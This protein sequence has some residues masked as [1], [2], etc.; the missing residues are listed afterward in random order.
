MGIKPFF[1]A[2]APLLILSSVSS[3]ADDARALIALKTQTILNVT[4][5]TLEAQEINFSVPSSSLTHGKNAEESTEALAQQLKEMAEK[6]FSKDPSTQ[7]QMRG[8]KF[9]KAASWLLNQTTE[10]YNEARSLARN[11]GWSAGI[12]YLICAVNDWA[13]PPLLLALGQPAIAAAILILPTGVM[14]TAGFIA[15]K[16]VFEKRQLISL[17]GG[18]ESYRYYRE[19]EKDARGEFKLKH[20][21]DYLLPL[22]SQESF[23]I[24]SDN[25]L[26][27]TA[28]LFHLGRRERMSARDLRR[29]AFNAGM[30]RSE[31]K[32]LKREH[33]E[34]LIR[35]AMLMEYL[36]MNLGTEEK[37][38]L[39][40]NYPESFTSVDRLANLPELVKWAQ[41]VVPAT[42]CDP[43]ITFSQSV[44]RGVPVSMVMDVWVQ[45]VM[46]YLTQKF[47]GIHVHGL[48][49]LIQ[50]SR[51]LD[52]QAKLEGDQRW[53][54]SWQD[55][56]SEA[57]ALACP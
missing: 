54:Q 45:V 3:Y 52:I 12:V 2:I 9:K 38:T 4:A 44:P 30:T 17:Y 13:S 25:L 16:K 36:E 10:A 31:F 24:P 22:S 46:P 21:K 19:L 28:T 47:K 49:R 55:R 23:V 50:H 41:E 32:H 37:E 20:K 57:V 6:T 26:Q 56:L 42:Q 18:K 5:A 35:S 14:I 34:K 39:R 7:E 15:V 51:E 1:G 8:E 53:D 29:K 11:E 43:L 27:R 33:D 48:H 40:E